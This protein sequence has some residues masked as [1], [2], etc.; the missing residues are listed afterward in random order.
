MLRN[1]FAVFIMVHGRPDRAWTYETL[2]ERGYTGRI[3]LV[4]DNLDETAPAYKERYGEELI[5]FDK[6]EAAKKYDSGDNTADLRST[7]FAANTIFDLAAERGIHY[8]AIMCDDYTCFRY[9]HPCEKNE[10]LLTSYIKDL[11]KVFDCYVDFLRDSNFNT[12]ALAQTGDFIG[13]LNSAILKEP[14]RRKAMNSFICSVSNRFEFIGRLNEDVTTYVHQGGKGQL[15]GTFPGATLD[16]QPTQGHKAGLTEVYKDTGTYLKSFFSV[17]YNPSC[18][19][20]SMMGVSQKRIHHKIHWENA[21][22]KIISEK[23]KKTK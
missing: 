4:A 15:F 12:V 14:L 18:V 17:M 10:S 5:V 23:N 7:M 8:F 21:V 20:I 13:G 6:L 3:F 16:Q 19:S 22:P 9:R 1:N 2:K 11:D